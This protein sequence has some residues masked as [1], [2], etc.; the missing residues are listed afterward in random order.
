ML[1]RCCAHANRPWQLFAALSDALNNQVRLVTTEK[2]TLVE[3]A[4]KMITTI[5]QMEASLDDG[6]PRR[7]YQ[8]DELKITYPLTR[9]LQ[10]LKEKHM[11]VSRLHR[12]RYEQVKSMPLTPNQNPILSKLTPCRTGPSP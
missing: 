11:Q 6:R 5:R 10:T 2:K 7:D 3:D 12:E 8:D 9:C 1:C 4:Q